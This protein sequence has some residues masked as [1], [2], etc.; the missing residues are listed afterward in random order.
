M[1]LVPA[2]KYDLIRLLCKALDLPFDEVY[3]DEDHAKGGL[4]TALAMVDAFHEDHAKGGLNTAL[5]MVDAFHEKNGVSK[6]RRLFQIDKSL[7]DTL[8]F[9]S[10]QLSCISEHLLS[11]H[12][13]DD[14]RLLRAHLMCE[15]LAELLAAMMHHDEE[16]TLDAL[17][18]LLYVTL[19]TAVTLDL[20]LAEA[21]VE[22]HKSN[23][24]KQKQDDD[25]D[26]ERLR[27]KGPDYVA[28]NLEKILT[29]Y[30]AEECKPHVVISQG[31]NE[32]CKHCNMSFL[33]IMNQIDET[34]RAVCR[35]GA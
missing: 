20:P 3:T 31:A 12:L 25:P 26:G 4:N 6:V 17:A 27:D 11:M 33:Q 15:E 29:L 22:V 8:E 24:T 21:F 19:G 23:M 14:P 28:P 5:A 10:S 30:R 1:S 35:G 34:G 9:A 13:D 7:S 32:F 16:R 2:D 18:D